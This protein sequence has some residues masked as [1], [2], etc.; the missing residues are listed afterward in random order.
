M[1][2]LGDMSKGAACIK[3]A[4]AKLGWVEEIVV[5]HRIFYE[6]PFSYPVLSSLI[7][8][9]FKSDSSLKK[10]YDIFNLVLLLLFVTL[11]DW[12]EDKRCISQTYMYDK[13]HLIF[14]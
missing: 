9:W 1:V 12:L 5:F 13:F 3:M 11:F 2:K 10:F 8:V 14:F 6:N 7:R 4:A